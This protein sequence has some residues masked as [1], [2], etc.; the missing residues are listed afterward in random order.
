MAFYRFYFVGTEGHFVSADDDVFENDEDA[1]AA[2]KA[3]LGVF[4]AAEVW[5]GSRFVGRVSGKAGENRK[6]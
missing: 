3:K 6:G 5:T 4:P 2:A 1:M